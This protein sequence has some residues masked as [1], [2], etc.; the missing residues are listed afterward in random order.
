MPGRGNS[1]RDSI[2]PIAV[3]RRES[4]NLVDD[5][6]RVAGRVGQLH[7]RQLGRR[8][9]R[10]GRRRTLLRRLGFCRFNDPGRRRAGSTRSPRDGV[11]DRPHRAIGGGVHRVV[12]LRGRSM[13]VRRR[14][15]PCRRSRHARAADRLRRRLALRCQPDP[16]Q[17][18][19]ANHQRGPGQYGQHG[20][21]PNRPRCH[22]DH[23][24]SVRRRDSALAWAVPPRATG[25][26]AG[27]GIAARPGN[28]EAASLAAIRAAHGA[29]SFARRPTQGAPAVVSH[30]RSSHQVGCRPPVQ[31]RVGGVTS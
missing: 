24:P 16:H 15:G 17:V 5:L 8:S 3:P 25:Q 19:H 14:R 18:C 21:H 26:T 7:R 23:L 10:G 13:R 22:H 2:P 27:Q 31:A 6:A 1:G 9:L 20:Q 28:R 12:S 4:G 30:F 29:R 11:A